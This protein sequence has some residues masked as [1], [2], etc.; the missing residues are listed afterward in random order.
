M[1]KGRVK[2]DLAIASVSVLLEMEGDQCR[3]ARIAA[4]SVAP[5]PLRLA[6]V[7]KLLEGNII[8]IEILEEAQRVAAESVAPITDI[9]AGAEYRRRIIGV[10]VKRAIERLMGDTA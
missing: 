5:V 9:R 6:K 1:K 4:G 2:M 8:S 3:R 10:Y 7:E